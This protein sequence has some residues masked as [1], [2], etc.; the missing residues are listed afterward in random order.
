M[1]LLII[2]ISIYVISFACA[3]RSIRNWHIANGIRLNMTVV[4]FT[5]MPVFNTISAIAFAGYSE[6]SKIK[7]NLIEAFFGVKEAR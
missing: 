3:R 5:I 6:E 2:A 7:R 1:I 4:L